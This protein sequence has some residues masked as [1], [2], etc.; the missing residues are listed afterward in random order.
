MRWWLPVA[1]IE[2]TVAIDRP[3]IEGLIFDSKLPF[4]SRFDLNQ[5][6]EVRTLFPNNCFNYLRV[7][8]VGDIPEESRELYF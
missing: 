6:I 5:K 4:V 8:E 1:R 3:R 2:C 7:F